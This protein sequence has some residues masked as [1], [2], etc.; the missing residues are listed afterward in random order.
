MRHDSASVEV[1]MVHGSSYGAI[2]V[3]LLFSEK[4]LDTDFRFPTIFATIDQ[5]NTPVED[6]NRWYVYFPQ[7][8]HQ[9]PSVSV[10]GC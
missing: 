1:E 9:S 3:A 6:P 8:Q 7:F 2:S 4:T 5:R 10:V